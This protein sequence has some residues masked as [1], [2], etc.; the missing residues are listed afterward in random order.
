[1]ILMRKSLIAAALGL[2]AM[3]YTGV[4]IADVTWTF[5]TGNCDSTVGGSCSGGSFSDSRTY[6]GSSGSIDVNVTGWSNTAGNNDAL[7]LGEITHYSGG[8]GIRNSDYNSSGSD[9][10]NSEGGTPEHAVDNDQRFDLVLFDFGAANPIAL[11]DIQIGYV[12]GVGNNHCPS[13]QSFCDADITLLAYEGGDAG[14]TSLLD[15]RLLTGSTE[16]LRAK[17]WTLIDNYDMSPD[18]GAVNPDPDNGGP[19]QRIASSRWIVMAHSNAFGTVCVND[20]SCANNNDYFKIASVSGKILPPP[21]P[22]P[23]PNTGSVPMPAP[24]TLLGLGLIGLGFA[25]GRKTR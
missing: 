14:D 5:S 2:A 12:P 4:S 17:G 9:R 3:N 18:D 22:P 20:S 6:E 19:A 7:E 21:P 16:D 11:T 25:N 15:G 23:P 24:L 8:L 10:D 1:M 13:N